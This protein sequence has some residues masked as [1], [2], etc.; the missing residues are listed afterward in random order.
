MMTLTT[1]RQ[2]QE[3]IDT[4]TLALVREVRGARSQGYVNRR[5]GF[6]FNQVTKWERG[7]KRVLWRDFV[8]LCT[9]CQTDLAGAL[10]SAVAFTGPSHDA[11][12]LVRHLLAGQGRQFARRTFSRST[13]GRWL[14][15]ALSPSLS[16]VL[17]LMEASPERRAAFVAALHA[18]ALEKAA[19]RP[20]PAA[21]TASQVPEETHGAAV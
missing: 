2:A 6:R 4:A 19:R 17:Q 12:A 9:V 20:S 21:T 14:Q 5:L 15:G 10:A 7:T 1:E 13:I 16:Q 11:P 3:A 8:A 18:S